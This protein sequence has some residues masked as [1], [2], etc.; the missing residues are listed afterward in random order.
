[1]NK[2]IRKRKI[3]IL[4]KVAAE[5]DYEIKLPKSYPI[6]FRYWIR[7]H[8]YENKIDQNASAKNKS[9][10]ANFFF[11]NESEE[12]KK[13]IYM[14][15]LLIQDARDD[16]HVTEEDFKRMPKRQSEG[17]KSLLYGKET[18]VKGRGRVIS[19][20]NSLQLS[21]FDDDEYE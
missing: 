4:F 13:K 20:D 2:K 16:Q 6:E 19:P 11:K 10:R 21:L 18:G 17:I 9:I 5:N 15:W 14:S 3:D 7:D 1:M 8:Y 12:T